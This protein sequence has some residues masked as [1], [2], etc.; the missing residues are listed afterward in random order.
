MDLH[1]GGGDHSSALDLFRII[2]MVQLDFREVEEGY[3]SIDGDFTWVVSAY[4]YVVPG[5][6]FEGREWSF[7]WPP[8][9]FSALVSA[10]NPCPWDS[11]RVLLLH[12]QQVAFDLFRSDQSVVLD[13]ETVGLVSSSVSACLR[14]LLAAVAFFFCGLGS[15]CL[16]L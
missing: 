7:S 10:P 8:I 12:C 16:G 3:V 15:G 5:N 4:I 1:E 13:S 14:F 2:G 6:A 11:V 9:R